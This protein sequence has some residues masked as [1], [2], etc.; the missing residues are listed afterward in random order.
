MNSEGSYAFA[1]AESDQVWFFQIIGMN[2][3]P[4]RR[5]LAAIENQTMVS[6]INEHKTQRLVFGIRK[7]FATW[8]NPDR[9]ELQ[10]QRN[11]EF[12]NSAHQL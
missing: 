8:K 10:V 7:G 2:E 5:F 9:S 3:R 1:C 6:F 11:R 12:W 4:T